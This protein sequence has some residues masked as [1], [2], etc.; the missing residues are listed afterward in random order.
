M[1]GHLKDM[2]LSIPTL[3]MSAIITLKNFKYIRVLFKLF[4]LLQIYRQPLDRHNQAYIVNLIRKPGYKDLAFLV[5]S[6]KTISKISKTVIFVDL[7][8]EPIKMTKYLQ[9][10]LSELIQNDEK[11]TE[12]IIHAFSANL[13]TTSRTKFLADLR[14]NDTQI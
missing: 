3:L 5:P 4:S 7:I 14:L 12:V 8:D 1:L 9:L 11:K 2:F 10:R 13:L 6:G